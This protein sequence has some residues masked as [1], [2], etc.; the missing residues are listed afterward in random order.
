MPELPR[1]NSRKI[2]LGRD[3]VDD[4]AVDARVRQSLPVDAVESIQNRDL[5]EGPV[6][7]HSALQLTPTEVRVELVQVRSQGFGHEGR[8]PAPRSY[9][10]P[11]ANGAEPDWD[12]ERVDN[13]ISNNSNY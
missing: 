13:S 6:V 7:N 11:G 3:A 2:E 8:G 9:P 5:E 10:A 12:D 1:P 4:V